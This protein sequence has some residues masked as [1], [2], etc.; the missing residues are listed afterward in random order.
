MYLPPLGENLNVAVIEKCF[1][2][3]AR[4][5]RGSDVSRIE[6]VSHEMLSI[7]PGHTYQSHKKGYDYLYYRE[8]IANL[9]GNPFKSKRSSYNQFIKNHPYQ[10]C[11]YK[12]DA[13]EECAR[14]YDIWANHKL[15]RCQNDIEPHMI[16]E[17][18]MVHR[19]CIKHTRELGLA[20]RVVLVDNKI[21]AYAFGYP[22]NKNVFCILFE[23]TNPNI[24][25]LPAF[26]FREFCADKEIQ[27]FRFINVMDD[28]ESES[29]R[30]VKLSFHPAVLFP[31]Y[32]VT[33]KNTNHN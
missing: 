32:V 1:E 27:S 13:R 29:M 20:G 25:G 31:A 28:S 5:N 2:K 12:D 26:I 11:P 4:H 3:M 6:N 24:K 19:E 8:D 23:I 21:A 14:L 22:L 18:R 33:Q 17:N 10:Y 7:F 16:E 15:S 9:T 30:R